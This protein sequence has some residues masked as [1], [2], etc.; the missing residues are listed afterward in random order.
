MAYRAGAA[1]ADL[2]FVQF[3]PT[4][5]KVAGQPRFLLSEALRGEGARLLNARGEAVHAA[6]R[7]G[8]RSRAA[9]SRRARHRA[10]SASA[11]ARPVYLSLQHLDPAF[12]H[13]RFPLISEACRRAGL[14]LARDRIPVGPAAHYVMGGVE[15]DLDGRTSIAGPVRRRRGRVHRRPRRQPAGEQLAAR[16]A[17]VRRARRAGDAR[18]AGRRRAFA[19]RRAASAR[20]RPARRFRRFAIDRPRTI[21]AADV[22]GRRAVPRS[23]RAASALERARA[24]MAR[25]RRSGCATADRSTPHELADGEP[26]HRRPADRA[27]GA[28]ARGEP[29]RALPRRL[30][31]SATIYTGNAGSLRLGERST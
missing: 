7:S 28:A 1:V 3:H 5:L 8:R 12:V 6:L 11:P 14:D 22:A 16:G 19:T 10:R 24:G 27:R 30:S 13:E 26:A 29:R 2:E 21:Q 20:G 25:R 18:A 23:R 4:A 17:G 15:T 31:R 9:R